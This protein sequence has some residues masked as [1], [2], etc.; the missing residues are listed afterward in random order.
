MMK[1]LN[2]L[3]V[4]LIVLKLADILSVGWLAVLLPT[5][6]WLGTLIALIGIYVFAHVMEEREKRKWQKH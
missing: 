3:T 1:Y 2:L 6:I 5:I 4:I